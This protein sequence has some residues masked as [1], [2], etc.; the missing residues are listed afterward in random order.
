[1]NNTKTVF[2]DED[3]EFDERYDSMNDWPAE[4]YRDSL[5]EWISN[6]RNRSYDDLYF[7]K[8]L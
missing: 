2:N 5:D 4:E 8:N 6:S 3:L 7:S 1:M